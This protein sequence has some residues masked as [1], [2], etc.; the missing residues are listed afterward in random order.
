MFRSMFEVFRVTGSD[1]SQTSSKCAAD[2]I[3]LVS[4][5]TVSQCR[6]VWKIPLRELSVHFE[7][8]CTHHQ[9]EK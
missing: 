7:R 5:E 4:Q 1:T 3:Q 9:Y 2:V 8:A 6:D